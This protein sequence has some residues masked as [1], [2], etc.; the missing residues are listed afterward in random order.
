MGSL[1]IAIDG[2]RYV[3]VDSSMG[4]PYRTVR[5]RT[6][7]AGQDSAKLDFCVFRKKGPVVRKSLIL[8]GLSQNGDTPSELRL[9]VERRLFAV[10]EINVRI[11]DG[12][13]E[14]LRVRTGNG[15]WPLLIAAAVLLLFGGCLLFRFVGGGFSGD[16][17]SLVPPA[18]QYDIE[19]ETSP[20][21]TAPVE[22]PAPQLPMQTIVYFRPERAD[23][24]DAAM[25]E[26]KAL[27][28]MLG[29]DISIEVGG[30]C[31]NYGT[32][33]G[34]RA[35]SRL[36]ADVVVAYLSG[37]I[38][39]SVIIEVKGYGGSRPLSRD[40]E[41]QDVNRRVEINVTGGGE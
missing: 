10:W 15:L 34:R 32:E 9:K 18:V 7:R 19:V 40:S 21:Q 36:R 5:L 8:N 6:M 29:E 38:H 12:T 1:G 16:S 30:H 27:A 41:S 20:V 2:G 24:S 22:P 23:L 14:N 39:S 13:V 26:L 33:P 37:M 35:L 4:D 28:G 31:A 11:H 17:R 3:R 25:A